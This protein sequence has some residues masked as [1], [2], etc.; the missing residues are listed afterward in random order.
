MGSSDSAKT[1]SARGV[2]VT[3]FPWENLVLWAGLFLVLYALQDVFPIVFLTFLLTYLVRAI[4]VPLARR[5]SP[6]IERPW[7][8]RG[9]TLGTFVGIVALLWGLATL[10]VPQFVLQGRL[11]A[12]NVEQLKPQELLDHVLARTVGAYLF[13]QTYGAPG[14][15]RYQSALDAFAAKGQT[16]EGAFASFARLR[17]QVHAGFEIAYEGAAKA[18][19]RRQVNP[20]GDPGSSFDH[21]FLTFKAPLLVAEHRATYLARL[22]PDAATASADAGQLEQRLAELALKDLVRDPAGRARLV[23]EWEQAEVAQAWRTLKDSA[24]YRDAFTAWFNGPE[25]MASRVPYDA[26][27]YLALRDAYGEGMES[28]KGVYR[29]RVAESAA[30]TALERLDFQRARE[31]D[32]A[33]QWWAGSPAAASLREH[34]QQDATEAASAVADRI[35]SAVRGLIAVPA[36]IGTALLLTILISFDMVGLKKGAQR[37]RQC[38][39]A[40][41][42]AKAVPSLTA[43]ARL[44]GRSFA[45][46]GIIAVFNTLLSLA[47]MRLLGVQNELLLAFVV[48]I[49]SFIPVLGII[50]SAIPMTLQALLQ[51]DGS[52]AMALY[53]LLGIGV[54]HAIE[55]MVLSPRIVGKILHLHP[56]LVLAVLVVGEHLFGIWGLLLGVPVAVFAIHAGILAD[57]IPGIYE[58]GRAADQDLRPESGSVADGGAAPS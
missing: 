4:V 40:G 7:L 10:M 47:L 9:L 55:S 42:Y 44:I 19:L 35:A 22:P 53:A 46:Q 26:A 6:K 30:G 38:R 36:Q 20:A 25:G 43:V 51:P 50:L 17:A 24:E 3:R 27:T 52:L 21:W 48:F 49:A 8:E 58:P 41:L 5:I 11:L 39:L 29:E 23:T 45:A 13:R 32:L 56:V 34:L 12:A 28:F 18:R 2:A 57:S 37:L 31:L 16:G 14:D 33:R 54:I 1:A 15:P